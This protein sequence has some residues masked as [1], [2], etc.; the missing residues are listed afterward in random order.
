MTCTQNVTLLQYDVYAQQETAATKLILG[1]GCVKRMGWT[2]VCDALE[3]VLVNGGYKVQ[4][5]KTQAAFG[6]AGGGE[7]TRATEETIFPAPVL[8]ADLRVC[9]VPMG[10][11]TI[12][13][14]LILISDIKQRNLDSVYLAKS[15]NFSFKVD[16][17]RSAVKL[18]TTLGGHRVLDVFEEQMG[19]DELESFACELENIAKELRHTAKETL[20][21]RGMGRSR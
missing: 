2:E 10:E 5:N 6:F 21:G 19:K 1:T 14:T 4:H 15:G 18:E 13:P 8:G 3:Q 9:K 7:A 16:N 11:G 20:N 12:H 17:R